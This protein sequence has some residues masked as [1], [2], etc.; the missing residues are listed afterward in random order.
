MTT[1][2]IIGAMQNEIDK[3]ITFYNLKKDKMNKDIYVSELNDKK[4]VV[5]MSGVG[6]V[7]S[8]A[9]TQ[10]IID[11][12]NTDAIINS[13]VAGGINNKLKVMDIIISNYVTYHDF[14]PK[15]IMESYVPN[16]GK[17]EANNTLVDIA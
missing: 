8:A 4:I 16:R 1:I 17:I 10:Y 7:N 13:G 15:T 9:M 5:A 11:K 2:G 3:L 6:K 12:Y 14:M